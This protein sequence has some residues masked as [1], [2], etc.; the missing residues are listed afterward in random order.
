MSIDYLSCSHC[1]DGF[2]DVI[3]YISC[4]C[5]RTW[6]CLECA[7]EDGFMEMPEIGSTEEEY[8]ATSCKYCREE[9]FD[10]SEL[11]EFALDFFCSDREEIIEEY[12]KFKDENKGE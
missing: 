7:E 1:G 3:D 10:D 5:G 9:D 6:C 2:P 8:P 12:K 11:L 4:D